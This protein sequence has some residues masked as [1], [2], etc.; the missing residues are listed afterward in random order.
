MLTL[1]VGLGSGVRGSTQGVGGLGVWLFSNE[2]L[3]VDAYLLEISVSIGNL[4]VVAER[5]LNQ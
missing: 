5:I 2:Q 1:Y 3:Q 4:S